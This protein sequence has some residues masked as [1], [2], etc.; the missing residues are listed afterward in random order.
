MSIQ[1]LQQDNPELRRDLEFWTELQEDVDQDTVKS[2]NLQ[3]YE[4]I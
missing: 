3:D 2:I 1:Q 4:K